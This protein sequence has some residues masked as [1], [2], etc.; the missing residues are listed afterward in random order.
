[1]RLKTEHNITQREL[2][3]RQWRAALRDLIA[4]TIQHAGQER[5]RAISRRQMGDALYLLGLLDD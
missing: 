2:R 1:M 3:A 5:D 4:L